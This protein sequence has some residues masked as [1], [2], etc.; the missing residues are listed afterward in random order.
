MNISVLSKNAWS[1]VGRGFATDDMGRRSPLDA[2]AFEFSNFRAF[3]ILFGHNTCFDD[4]LPPTARARWAVRVNLLIGRSA[5]TVSA[6]SASLREPI[7]I[8]DNTHSFESK[9]NF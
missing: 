2:F 4:G 1:V 6:A 9:G 5:A 3:V 8:P 7:S